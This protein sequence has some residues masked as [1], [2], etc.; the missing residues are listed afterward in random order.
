MDAVI[1]YLVHTSTRSLVRTHHFCF[2][3]TVHFSSRA[4]TQSTDRRDYSLPSLLCIFHL[5]DN[6][7][8]VKMLHKQRQ[9]RSAKNTSC[10][11]KNS[12]P[13]DKRRTK[14]PRHQFK[15]P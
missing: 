2:I 13:T 7:H 4:T 15:R 11:S 5:L 14:Y 12:T 6:R 1:Y 3:A 10:A 8:T 9:S